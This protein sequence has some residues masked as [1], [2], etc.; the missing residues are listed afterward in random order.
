MS[1]KMKYVSMFLVSFFLIVTGCENQKKEFTQTEEANRKVGTTEEKSSNQAASADTQEKVEGEN[2]EEFE[3]GG[4]IADPKSP[5]RIGK[6]EKRLGNESFTNLEL[7]KYDEDSITFIA[8]GNSLGVLFSANAKPHVSTYTNGKW[9]KDKEIDIE[10]IIPGSSFLGIAKGSIDVK[11]GDSEGTHIFVNYKGE[12][13]FKEKTGKLAVVDVNEVFRDSKSYITSSNKG[14]VIVHREN[15]NEI[16]LIS[17]KDGKEMMKLNGVKDFP[18]SPGYLDL[19]KKLMFQTTEI[20][21]FGKKKYV[22]D[23]NGQKVQADSNGKVVAADNGKYFFVDKK[24]TDKSTEQVIGQFEV[25]QQELGS[26]SD[27]KYKIGFTGFYKDEESYVI[28]N[29][30]DKIY[31]YGY[32]KF[33]DKPAIFMSETTYKKTK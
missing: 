8:E 3:G 17:Q 16:T 13:V 11:S 30:G 4:R 7:D 28:T 10:S 33:K 20:Y 29:S 6:V 9:M 2:S 21:D 15:E 12:V 31:F 23:S 18:T 25:Y 27:R 1:S 14:N 32:Y 5:L 19:D 22:Y 26:N 24:N